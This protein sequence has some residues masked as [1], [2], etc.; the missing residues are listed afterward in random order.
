MP[1]THPGP[2]HPHHG[3]LPHVLGGLLTRFRLQ[4]FMR[5]HDRTV[6]LAAFSFVNGCLSLALLASIAAVTGEPFIFPSLGPA[7]FLF[8]YAP[9]APSA[10]P[11]NTVLGHLVGVCAGWVSLQLFGLAHVGPALLHGV[12]A[13][14]ILA[15]AFSL[16]LTSGL[17]V[18]LRT[19]HPPAAATTLI[20]SLGIL[21]TAEQLAVLMGGVALLTAWAFAINRLA[22]LPYPVWAPDPTPAELR[23]PAPGIPGPE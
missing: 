7:A 23:G 21:T 3:H 15:A 20:I 13:P 9:L 19:P 5:H 1:L 11:R 12:S 22:G 14:R 4:R 10:S 6:V 16:G 8:F 18:L 17:M 2:P